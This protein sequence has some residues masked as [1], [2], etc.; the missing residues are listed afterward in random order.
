M[1]MAVQPHFGRIRYSLA[2]AVACGLSVAACATTNTPPTAATVTAATVTAA[3][4]PTTTTA[5]KVAAPTPVPEPRGEPEDGTL[6]P[7]E[8]SIEKLFGKMLPQPAEPAEPWNALKEMKCLA[9]LES[10]IV[11]LK[12][13]VVL[14][15]PEVQA[16]AVRFSGDTEWGDAL[17]I[18]T[19][20]YSSGNP[21]PTPE[22]FRAAVSAAA[23][24]VNKAVDQRQPADQKRDI[25][26]VIELR[27]GNVAQL[28]TIARDEKWVGLVMAPG[29]CAVRVDLPAT[30]EREKVLSL[31]EALSD[32]K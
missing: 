25:G 21:P 6:S 30:T 26:E 2:V 11:K 18:V 19:L 22:E 12:R 14:G 15:G 20:P 27:N 31:L 24:Q 8:K 28:N 1:L 32:W 4:V 23:D 3:T 7:Y 9:G 10:S 5:L 16:R 29:P 13:S 17:F